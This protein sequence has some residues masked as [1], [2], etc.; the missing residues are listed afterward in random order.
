MNTVQIINSK[1]C[2]TIAMIFKAG[3]IMKV[4]PLLLLVI[5]GALVTGGIPSITSL[6][7][8][9]IVVVTVI[10]LGMQLN[11][12]TD[13]EVDKKHKPYLLGWLTRDKN[14]LNLILR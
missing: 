8:P 4:L 6:I 1:N 10:T 11:V 7:L 2:E 13:D 3:R 9:L 14:I 12:I 5:N